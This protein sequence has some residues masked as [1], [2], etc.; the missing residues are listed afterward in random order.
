MSGVVVASLLSAIAASAQN[1]PGPF[2]GPPRAKSK[3]GV[4][5][6]VSDRQIK[7]HAGNNFVRTVLAPG[8]V[9]WKNGEKRGLAAVRVGDKVLMR[10]KR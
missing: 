6:S 5:T 7:V 10:G 1:P 9:V 8:A 3:M 2:S 4:V